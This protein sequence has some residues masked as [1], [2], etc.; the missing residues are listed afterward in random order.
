MG[1]LDQSP[2]M[3]FIGSGGGSSHARAVGINNEKAPA[4]REKC[5]SFGV[6][7]S[8][9][10]KG[11]LGIFTTFQAITANLPLEDGCEQWIRSHRVGIHDNQ[12]ELYNNNYCICCSQDYS[13]FTG[14]E[15]LTP[16]RTGKKT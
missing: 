2:G 8:E 5:Q 11:G 7:F 14:C 15:D 6:P 10:K 13:T 4:F 3:V 16:I 12:S 1:Q 9:T